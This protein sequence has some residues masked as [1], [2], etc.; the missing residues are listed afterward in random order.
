MQKFFIALT[1]NWISLAGTVLTT[2]AA[3][4]TLTLFLI[5]SFGRHHGPYVGILAYLIVPTFF[6]VG[7]ILIPIG[8]IRERRLVRRAAERGEQEPGFPVFDLNNT[9]TRRN[10]VVFFLLTAVNVVIVALATYKG[11]EVMDSTE[12]CGQTCH[13]VMTPEFTAYQNSP[14][15]RVKCVEC[16]IGPGAD[17]FVK[18]K[19]SGTWQVVSV[20]FDLYPRPTPTPVHALRPA[21]DTCEQCHWP[22]KFLG[23]QLEIKTHYADDEANTELKTVLLLRVGGIQGRVAQGI[24]WH[25]DPGLQIRYR[26][27]ESR[28]TIHE[29]ELTREDGTVTTYHSPESKANGNADQATGTDGSGA[30]EE[31]ADGAWRVMDCVDCHNRPT[32][33]YRSPEWG[34]DESI[35]DG[36]ISRELP[37]IRREA[38]KALKAADYGSH[39]EA[40]AGLAE[41]I[42]AYYRDGYP[43]IASQKTDLVQQAAR[44]VGEIYCR[45]VF[46][47][48]NVTWGT[49]PDHIGHEAYPGC[50]RCHNDEHEAADGTV[51]SQDCDT[52]HTLL[53]YEEE[54]PEILATLQP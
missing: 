52:C 40:R 41:T 32:H 10:F 54:N 23:D 37:Y 29:V 43:E 45:N 2:A 20:A 16:H 46:P 1:R 51:I 18:S 17:W 31:A 36:R 14:H 7:L 6:V 33:I 9:A 44:E 26:S 11:V 15:A 27:D 35:T 39:D 21:R 34:V 28:E 8:I 53:A 38:V 50:F 48:M 47:T 30:I 13:T 42:T 49:Y 12:F 24:H 5:D 3:T 25:V 22:T 4:L 19:L